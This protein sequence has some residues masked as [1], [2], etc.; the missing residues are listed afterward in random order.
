MK[1]TLLGAM[2]GLVFAWD[3]AANSRHRLRRAPIY[4]YRVMSLME[5]FGDTQKAKVMAMV[6]QVDGA[7]NR[8]DMMFPIPGGPESAGGSGVGTGDGQ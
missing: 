4:E 3:R 7:M 6:V 8:T 2:L 1:W 5:M